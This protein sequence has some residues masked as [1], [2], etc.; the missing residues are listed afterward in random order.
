VDGQVAWAD[1][2]STG[3]NPARLTALLREFAA[4]RVGQRL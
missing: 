1:I 3:R 2:S 4:G